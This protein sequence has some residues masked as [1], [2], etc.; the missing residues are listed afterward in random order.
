MKKGQIVEGTVTDVK[1]PNK[2]IV[3]CE[4]GEVIVKGLIP[5]Q[6]VSA[7]IT[8]KHG[9]RYEGRLL[10]IIKPSPFEDVNEVCPY[11]GICGGCTYQSV[12]YEKQLAIKE[13]Q[14]KNIIDAVCTDYEFLGITASPITG[15]YRNKMEF[16]FGD[17][18]MD[19]PLALGLHK[20]GSF[21]D[22]VSVMDC[23]IIDEDY[24]KILKATLEYFSNSG[25]TYY[26]KMKHTGYL[27]H[28]LVRKA[29]RTGEIMV[30]LVT[31]TQNVVDLAPYAE[32][33]RTL[34]YKGKLVSV[35][36]TVNDS[37]SDA[38]VNEG[39]AVLYGRDYIIEKLFD[40]SFK[41]TPFSFFQTN[42]LGAEVL[43]EKVREFAGDTG[44]KTIFDLYSGTGTI[45]QVLAPVAG[46][47]IG[48]EIVDEA[49][50]AAKINAEIN[51][52]QN[53]EFIAGDVLRVI[54]EL[55]DK[56]ELIILDPPRDGIHP[57]AILP[58][59]EFGVDNIVYVACKPT[60]VARDI[61][62]F[63]AHGY[64]VK[65]V[66]C[67]DMF[68]GTVHVETIALLSRVSNRK[69]D[70]HIKLSLDMDEYHD[71][72]EKEN[73]NDNLGRK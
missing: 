50:E 26:H 58:I 29:A 32:L 63:E 4:E 21:H 5:G 14:V 19:G 69:A 35:L 44:N 8:K 25:L 51:G 64:K 39:T 7:R 13:G 37:L 54:G 71:I 60:S 52:L 70:S 11:F 27:R 1:F 16:S 3:K 20:K 46:R 43:Y 9:D 53:C 2:S 67:V 59:I 33:L 6:S 24:R 42:T 55:K 36:H 48:V 15:E 73:A 65:K 56:P 28:L 41:I 12:N 40:L 62:I 22:I 31:T 72:V 45:A 49:V 34:E 61:Q 66:C 30:D 57:K 38:V 17:E 47:V 68:P 18:Y 23:K 10:D